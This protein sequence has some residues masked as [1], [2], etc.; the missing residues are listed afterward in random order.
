[1]DVFFLP[2]LL[3]DSKVSA[4]NLT[5]NTKFV[6][7]TGFKQQAQLIGTGKLIKNGGLV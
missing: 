6:M 3:I 4:N 5:Q 2:F 7:K 1:L